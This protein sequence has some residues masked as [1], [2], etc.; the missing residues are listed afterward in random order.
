M[1]LLGKIPNKVNI[2]FSG[3]IDSVAI[4]H[5]LMQSSRD[6]TL[7]YFNHGTAHG[8]EAESFCRNFA[9]ECGLPIHIDNILD[10]RHKKDDESKEE[11]WR[12][13]RYEFLNTHTEPMITCHHLDDEVE[14]WLFSSLHNY[15]KLIPYRRNHIIRPFLLNRKDELAEYVHKHDLVWIQDY[16]NYDITYPRNR[17]RHVVLPE[18]LKI[19]PGLYRVIARKVQGE[20]N[21]KEKQKSG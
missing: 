3:G 14:T 19:N 9:I 8:L 21:V 7:Y 6:I 1:K 2:A 5:F 10:Y 17:L 13:C 18:L 12:M 20:Y 15:P 4:T 11:Y 16:S